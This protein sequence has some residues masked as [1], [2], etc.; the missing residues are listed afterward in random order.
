[1][2]TMTETKTQPTISALVIARNEADMIANC[3]DSLQWCDEVIV[4]DNDSSDTTAELAKR[5]GARVV[6]TK[7]GFS[8]LRN[9]ALRRAK[10]DWV[11]YVDAD[12]RVVPAL[13]DEV[14]SAIAQSET[15]PHAPTAYSVR[16]SNVLYGYPMYYGGWQHDRVVRLFNRLKLKTWAGEVHEH[17]DIDGEVSELQ[18]PLLHL[19]HR[20]VV[21]GLLKTAEW[22]P[23]EAR[24]LFE[25][26]IPPVKL[27][28][29]FRKFGMELLRRGVKEQGYKDG[30]PGWIEALVQA[31]NRL[32][33]Y[34]QVWELQ[35]KPSLSARYRR[36]EELVAEL[37]RKRV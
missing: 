8:E 27:T 25:S 23:I 2:N 5:A 12:E 21:S 34:I 18:Q 33:V 31:T 4:V 35:Q 36:H 7:G 13:A 16:R 9:E 32:L 22:T 3:L 10:T 17:A 37:W 6:T 26:G 14:R 24:L 1:M 19:T 15:N 29:L 11:L 20:N 30:L 28:T